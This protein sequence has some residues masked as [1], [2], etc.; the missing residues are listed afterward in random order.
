[1]NNFAKTEEEILILTDK[2]LVL[3]EKIPLKDEVFTE[4]DLGCGKGG[5]TVGMAQ[6]YPERRIL[7]ADIM[8]GRL[9]KVKK[10]LKRN[11]CDE[12]VTLL[13]CEANMLLGLQLPDACIDR[14]HILC[15]DPWPKVRHSGRRLLSAQLM[16]SLHR[17]LKKDGIFHF[18]TDDPEYMAAVVRLVNESGFFVN[19]GEDAISDIAHIKTEFELD[20][21]A[22]GR[23]VPHVAWKKI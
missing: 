5:L 16:T 20:W 1:M 23:T 18:S 17:V 3:D 6:L 22:I 14:L 2:Y 10:R 15:P 7:A 21:L 19:A 12:N 4:L 13:R 8:L 11:S 9:R